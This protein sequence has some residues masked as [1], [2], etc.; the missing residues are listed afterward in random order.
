M[1]RLPFQLTASIDGGNRGTNRQDVSVGGVVKRF[2]FCGRL[3][4]Q[5][6]NSVPNNTF[7][8]NTFAGRI[9]WGGQLHEHQRDGPAHQYEYGVPNGFHV[10]DRRRLVSDHRPDI[11]S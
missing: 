7:R 3:P 9:G 6:D 2:D 4:F 8:N 1:A 10:Q 5:T 11:V